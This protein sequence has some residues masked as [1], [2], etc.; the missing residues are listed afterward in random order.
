LVGTAAGEVSSSARTT[1]ST[2][3]MQIFITGSQPLPSPSSS[4]GT[5]PVIEKL[6]FQMSKIS[7]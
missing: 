1:A 2:S 7:D 6:A 3:S 4:Y 5:S